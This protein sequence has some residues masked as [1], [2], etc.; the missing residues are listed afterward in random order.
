MPEKFSENTASTIVLDRSTYNRDTHVNGG[1]ARSHL[2]GRR[3]VNIVGVQDLSYQSCQ[4]PV[5]CSTIG[6]RSCGREPYGIMK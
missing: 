3:I 2:G 6:A 4:A 1:L 5:S